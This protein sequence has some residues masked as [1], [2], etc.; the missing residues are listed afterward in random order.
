MTEPAS[1]GGDVAI[2]KGSRAGFD[3]TI[4]AQ[5]EMAQLTREMDWRPTPVGPMSEW[6]QS[7]RSAVEIMLASATPC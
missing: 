1:V 2:P 5:G 3:A 6:P 4:P 7:L